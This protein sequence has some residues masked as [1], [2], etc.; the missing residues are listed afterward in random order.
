MDGREFS[1]SSSS[2]EMLQD[3]LLVV[4]LTRLSPSSVDE[5]YELSFLPSFLCKSERAV[6]NSD[7]L[8]S[9]FAS[10]SSSFLSSQRKEKHLRRFSDMRL[11]NLHR[12]TS[13]KRPFLPRVSPADFSD[14]FS[15]SDH[16][17]LHWKEHKHL[18]FKTSW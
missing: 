12:N 3:P 18:C 16:Q 11:E 4:Y 14:V 6:N 13:T 8:S 10:L 2:S 5:A 7:L 17:R 15:S 9:F 1:F